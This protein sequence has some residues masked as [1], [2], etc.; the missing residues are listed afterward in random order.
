MNVPVKQLYPNGQEEQHQQRVA[1]SDPRQRRAL[2]SQPESTKQVETQEVSRQEGQNHGRR[3]G[4][5]DVSV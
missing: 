2:G 3:V 4:E 1:A 5:V